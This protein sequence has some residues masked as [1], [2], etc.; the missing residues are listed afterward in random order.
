MQRWH[1]HQ[2]SEAQPQLPPMWQRDWALTW[3]FAAE[4]RS[5][6][7]DGNQQTES[8]PS[9]AHAAIRGRSGNRSGWPEQDGRSPFCTSLTNTGPARQ[10]P[11]ALAG[12][13]TNPQRMPGVRRR[14]TSAVR[15]GKGESGR[16]RGALSST[17]PLLCCGVLVLSF[18][19]FL[20]LPQPC[21]QLLPWETAAGQQPAPQRA[22]GRGASGGKRRRGMEFLRA[23]ASRSVAAPTAAQSQ[24]GRRAQQSGTEAQ[25]ATKGKGDGKTTAGRLGVCSKSTYTL[26][27]TALL[28][29]LVTQRCICSFQRT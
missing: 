6:Q 9:F 28:P 23:C 12:A 20:L 10:R 14:W 4:A 17:L 13:K 21:V 27:D 3:L 8:Q 11:C 2:R 25:Q 1:Y 26:F 29:L 15:A 19:P 16:E 24:G 5:Q 22:R 18:S 7:S